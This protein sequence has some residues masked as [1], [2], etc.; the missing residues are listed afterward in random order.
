MTAGTLRLGSTIGPVDARIVPALIR[1][2]E[3]TASIAIDLTAAGTGLLLD[4]AKSGKFDLV[5]VHA[6]RLEEAF[7]A[8]GFGLSRD[9]IMANDFVVLG[10]RD[11]PARIGGLSSVTEA[12]RAIA[13]ASAPFL[14]RGDRSGTHVKEMEIWEAL[15][16]EP[17]GAWYQQAAS[18]A[19]GNLATLREVLERGCYS[20]L[21]RATIIAQRG[22]L[23]MNVLVEGDALLLNIISVIPIDSQPVV[24]ANQAGALQMVEWLQQDEAQQFVAT[25]GVAEYGEPLFF[26]RAPVWR[27]TPTAFHSD[28]E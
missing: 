10:P 21:D 16:M 12:F 13:A 1:L 26:P 11:D 20:L 23:P 22:K 9:E 2:Y 5:I 14:T 28:G 18:G 24:G 7:I 3:V 6:R 27:Q 19:Q 25:F 17:S 15:G 8:D 4:Q